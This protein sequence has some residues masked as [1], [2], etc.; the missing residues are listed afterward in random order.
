MSAAVVV[1]TPS[2]SGGGPWLSNRSAL[3]Y[4]GIGVAAFHVA[5]LVEYV[6]ILVVVYLGCLIGLCWIRTTRQ[7]FYGGLLIGLATFSPQLLFFAGIFG[8]AAFGLWLI[9]S[10]WTSAFL[11]IGRSTVERWPR[12]GP[13]LLPIVWFGLEYFR[14]ELYY[15][16]FAWLTPGFAL[17]HDLWRPLVSFGVYGF[18]LIVGFHVIAWLK[19]HGYDRLVLI[20][21]IGFIGLV[22]FGASL[23]SPSS[24][25]GI[26]VVGIQWE[27]ASESQILESLTKAATD[28]PDSQVFVLPEYTLN[29]PPSTILRDWCKTHERYLIVGGK[30]PTGDG[31]FRNTAFVISPQ[32]EIVHRQV[33]SVPIQFFTDGL[34]AEKQE[35]WES[36]WGKV[37]I[38]ICYDLSYSRV[39]DRLVAD[40]ADVLIIPTMDLV[41]WGEYEHKLH[42]KVAPIRATEYGIPI[43]RVAS[44]GIS[45]SVKADG[46]VE[47]SAPFPG[48]GERVSGLLVFNQTTHRPPDRFLAIP[49]VVIVGGLILLLLIDHY[50]PRQKGE[51]G[52]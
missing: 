44:S 2:E 38:A 51:P 31:N 46:R 26:A 3:L 14:C 42:A 19:L 17:S 47:A 35:L 25:G 37:G 8:P 23:T 36:P 13:W 10:L 22:C 34:P 48:Q 39:I 30:D 33:K 20:P 28:H 41:S 50:R 4:A 7:A 27:G 21:S 16:R 6:G 32:G 49:A 24:D 40:G 9:L 12:L 11:L 29:A 15:L 1:D 5:Y 18:S 52:A 43:F 45:Q